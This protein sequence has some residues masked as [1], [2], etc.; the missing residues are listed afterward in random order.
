MFRY[1]I[2]RDPPSSARRGAWAS[3]DQGTEPCG[4]RI[5]F[6]FLGC[7]CLKKPV[8]GRAPFLSALVWVLLLLCDRVVLHT[9]VF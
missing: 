9:L 5:A 6:C 7:F 3:R 1:M 4:N 2:R 8:S